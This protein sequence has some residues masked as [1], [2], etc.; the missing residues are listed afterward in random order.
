MTR[1]PVVLLGVACK[2]GKQTWRSSKILVGLNRN[3]YLASYGNCNR[4]ELVSRF[5]TLLSGLYKAGRGPPSK[6]I[7]IHIAIQSDVGRRY[8]AFTAAEPG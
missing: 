8:Y 4:L 3:S 6:D 2:E 5:I 1:G 7:S